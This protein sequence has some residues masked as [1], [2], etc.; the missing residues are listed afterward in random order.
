LLLRKANTMH[1]KEARLRAMAEGR[2]PVLLAARRL[3]TLFPERFLF[4]N[5]HP[6]SPQEN[7]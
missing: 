2:S 7:P 3:L 4:T 1:L 6:S 5:F